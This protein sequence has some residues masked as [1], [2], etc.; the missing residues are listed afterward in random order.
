MRNDGNYIKVILKYNGLIEDLDPYNMEDF[1]YEELSPL[2]IRE[3]VKLILA[4]EIL[5]DEDLDVV[6][7]CEELL[8]L[9]GAI[10]GWELKDV[11]VKERC[12]GCTFSELSDGGVLL[13]VPMLGIDLGVPCRKVK[14][15][16]N[17]D[18]AYEDKA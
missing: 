6:V 1:S 18:K 11:T 5:G 16:Y 14:N 8:E 12:A 2:A 17:R 10:L 7:A 9:I 4:N 3:N 13:C 15:C